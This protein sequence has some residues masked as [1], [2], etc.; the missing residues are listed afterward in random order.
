VAKYLN[1]LDRGKRFFSQVEKRVNIAIGQLPRKQRR[2]A[3]RLKDFIRRR[4]RWIRQTFD[5][6][7]QMLRGPCTRAQVRTCC[8]LFH[9]AIDAAR[10]CPPEYANDEVGLMGVFLPFWKAVPSEEELAVWRERIFA[11]ENRRLGHGEIVPCLRESQLEQAAHDVWTAIRRLGGRGLPDP[12][13]HLTQ[14]GNDVQWVMDEVQ[15]FLHAAYTWCGE[16]ESRPARR[17]EIERTNIDRRA[18]TLAPDAGFF[19]DERAS[20]ADK[21]ES[22]LSPGGP[23]PPAAA[24][25]PT[26]APPP[27]PP[28][29]PP[30]TEEEYFGQ[31][32][33]ACRLVEYMKDRW[34]A[35]LSDVCP[36]VWGKHRSDVGDNAIHTAVSR[37]NKFLRKIMRKRQLHKPKNEERLVWR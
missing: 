30:I 13:A 27:P 31:E 34:E 8:S 20:A 29:E 37:A 28:L 4:W 5:K 18:T 24:E 6:A 17:T 1:K 19:N 2:V 9:E 15:R 25:R 26:P 11:W 14:A 10:R 32:G 21:G 7:T 3:L 35:D 16:N 33:L 12:P 36:A 22:P 23:S